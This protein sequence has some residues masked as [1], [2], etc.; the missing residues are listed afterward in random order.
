MNLEQLRTKWNK[1]ENTVNNDNP[2]VYLVLDEVCIPNLNI[3]INSKNNK[4][5]LL[6]IDDSRKQRLKTIL[7]ENIKFGYSRTYKQFVLELLDDTF[8]DL[9]NEL[10]ISIYSKTF[11]EKDDKKVTSTFIATIIKWMLFFNKGT[12]DLLS[13]S[14]IRGL[15]GEMI[16]LK[17]YLINKGGNRENEILEAW[18]GP[19]NSPTDFVFDN[20]LVEVKTK[21][22]DTTIVKISSEFQLEEIPGKELLLKVVSIEMTEKSVSTI[23]SVFSEI[24]NILRTEGGD[25]GLFMSAM[26]GLGININTIKLYDHY[27]YTP[28]LIEE[29]NCLLE[30]DEIG[31]PRIT[32]TSL[33]KQITKIKYDLNLST[34]QDYIVNTKEL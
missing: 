17:D 24:K 2:W 12:T 3:A 15:F 1:L 7:K 13:E 29:Y 23:S 14:I 10:V 22:I 18:Q 32:K 27:C 11:E 33:P 21:K 16:V 6:K 9:F 19:Y 20:A 30:L 31:F 5:I 8:L 4:C 25:L 28:L 34:L 26:N